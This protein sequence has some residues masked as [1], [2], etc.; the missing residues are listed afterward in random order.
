MIARLCS[1]VARI[2]RWGHEEV[3]N[4]DLRGKFANVW[5]LYCAGCTCCSDGL[6]DELI[7]VDNGDDRV[8]LERVI[9]QVRLEIVEL[10]LGWVKVHPDCREVVRV[11]PI[12]CMQV[13]LIRGGEN[14]FT[15]FDDT[16]LVEIESITFWDVEF[17]VAYIMFLS[18]C[19][20]NVID[21]LAPKDSWE[22][23]FDN[24]SAT[25]E[26]ISI[27]PEWLVAWLEKD[28][29]IGHHRIAV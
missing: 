5:E 10:E 11:G 28:W 6:G 21:W 2:G 16:V 3:T 26:I 24:L 20:S 27:F 9:F 4:C 23:G 18:I 17:I 7:G 25:H 29:R 19:T 15:A 14:T 12:N 8:I 13:E 1:G 22:G